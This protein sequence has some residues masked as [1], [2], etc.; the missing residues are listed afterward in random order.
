MVSPACSFSP[1]YSFLYGVGYVPEKLTT[2]PEPQKV[3]LFGN[4]VFAD[5]IKLR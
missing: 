5:V 3:T 1:S 4:S 2:F